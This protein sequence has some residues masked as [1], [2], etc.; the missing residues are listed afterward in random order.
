MTQRNETVQGEEDSGKTSRRLPLWV[1]TWAL[2][3]CV[4]AM[5]TYIGALVA[6]SEPFGSWLFAVGFLGAQAITA[7]H[8]YL[9]AKGK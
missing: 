5:I 9:L 3:L 7:G 2:L 4:F 6:T 8:V 1:M